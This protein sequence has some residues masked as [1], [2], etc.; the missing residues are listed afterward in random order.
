MKS[1]SKNLLLIATKPFFKNYLAIENKNELINYKL[2]VNSSLISEP[3]L[4]ASRNYMIFLSL[5]LETIL[6]EYSSAVA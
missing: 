5:D 6:Y 3:F 4:F 1:I 2:S